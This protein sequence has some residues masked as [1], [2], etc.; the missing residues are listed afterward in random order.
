M[1][2]AAAQSPA[3]IPTPRPST[4]GPPVTTIAPRPKPSRTSSAQSESAAA[5][6]GTGQGTATATATAPATTEKG[7]GNGSGVGTG[8]SAGRRGIVRTAALDPLSDKATSLLI[9]RI[10]C[11]QHLEKAAAKNSPPPIEELLPPLTSRN[12]VDLQLYAL[13]AIILRE[14]VQSWYNKITPDE[15]FVAEIVQ[16]IAHITR[17][18][19][20]RLRKV[21]LESLLFDEIPDLLDRHITAYRVA[22]DPITQPPLRTDPHEIYHSLSPLPALSPV[23]RPADPESVAEQA[24]NEV[25]YRQLLVHAVLA[26]LLPTEDLENRCLTALVGQI[27]SELI[28]GNTVANRLS[29]PW[30]ILEIFITASRT[31]KQRKRVQNEN[32]S[33]RQLGK[34]SSGVGSI[35]SSIQ[36]LF[37][38]IM[39]WC[40]LATSF[41]RLAFG[42]L[43]TSR[44]LP[45]R[46]SYGKVPRRDM[47]EHEVGIKPKQLGSNFLTDSEPVKTPV[48]AFKCW[49]AISNLVEMDGRMPW[50]CGVSSMLQWLLMTGPGRIA[51][52]DGKLD[53]LLSHGIQRHVLD[54]A[55]LPPLLRNVRGALFPNNAPGKPTLVAPSSDAELRALRRRC[56][57]SLWAL[58]PKGVGRLYFGG[59]VPGFFG[60][61][62]SSVSGSLQAGVAGEKSGLRP[63]T[64]RASHH[65]RH[66]SISSSAKKARRESDHHPSRSRTNKTRSAPPASSTDSNSG[67]GQGSGQGQ[68]KRQV[69][70]D[71]LDANMIAASREQASSYASS[72]S[73]SSSNNSTNTSGKASST[74]PRKHSVS[75]VSTSLPAPTITYLSEEEEILEEIERG[76]LDVFS[77]AYC[78]KH[79]VYS[80]LELVLVR[81]MPELAEKGVLE[82][83]AERVPVHI[84]SP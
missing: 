80:I 15:T 22:H 71:R 32:P 82:L 37:W 33:G 58:V 16:I 14:Y 60:G 38:T 11:P 52:V 18:L 21:D 1:T 55:S 66:E 50:V 17:A 29:A 83:W 25:A 13:I 67:S 39:Q 62:G 34:G 73:S 6:T 81:L 56:A 31:I 84:E 53:R 65:G 5:T 45:S 76:I 41:I 64:E 78:N 35:L 10:L 3:R 2:T 72:S 7:G 19:E 30:V 46:T 68:G 49:S 48:L 9:R 23:P 59:V 63:T 42:A 20:Q 70:N 69:G 51:A 24:E 74:R 28:V 57:S 47:A 4:P 43:M 61:S 79:L 12:D 36:A 77:D 8:G 40:F 26:I 27:V 54:A 44:S 75:P